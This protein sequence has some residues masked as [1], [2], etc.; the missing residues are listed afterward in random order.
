M[1]GNSGIS[2]GKKVLNVGGN[3]K[4]IPI[5]EHYAGWEHLMLDIDP[6]GNPDI[7]CDARRLD[8]LDGDQFD[9][10][11]C[12]HNLEHYFRHEVPKVLNGFNH[13]LR[14][15]GFVEIRV[16]DLLAVMQQMLSRN[17]D[18]EE[19]L[20]ISPAGPISALD[21]FYG[22]SGEIEHSG[23]DYFAHK[24]GFTQKSLQRTLV[25]HFRSVYTQP[26][27][28]EIR[29]LAF[30]GMPNEEQRRI[31]RLPETTLPS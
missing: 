19:P 28:L 8:T 21:I 12:S 7:V 11:Y 25:R 23:K 27:N 9:A 3:K 4:T 18:I 10:I 5:P 14:A 26:G 17:L 24:T 16:P 29:A 1:N 22:L 31:F 30:K 20:Y 2:I 6:R 15:D 13:V